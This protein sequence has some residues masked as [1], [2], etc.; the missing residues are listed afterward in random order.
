MG[1]ASYL[2]TEGGDCRA[3]DEYGEPTN[4]AEAKAAHQLA[5]CGGA[6]QSAVAAEM[7]E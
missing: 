1:R 4:V 7:G 3:Q 5:G 6:V 2:C